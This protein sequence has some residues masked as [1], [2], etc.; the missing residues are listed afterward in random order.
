[1]RHCLLA[2]IALSAGL[3]SPPA[4]AAQER[5]G[6]IDV[7][8][9]EDLRGAPLRGVTVTAAGTQ[10]VST[11][12]DAGGEAHFV[13]LPTGSYTVIATQRGYNDYH[14][15]NI[16]VATGMTVP[17]RIWMSVAAP[18]RQVDTRID[19]PLVETRAHTASTAVSFDELQRVPWTRDPW[20]VL[21]TV[22]AVIV[23]R[24]NVGSL[25]SGQQ[26]TFEAKGAPP[27]DNTWA[28]EGVPVTSM[29]APG[30]SMTYFDFGMLDELRVT[31]GGA[32]PHLASPGVQVNVLL[33]SGGNEWRGAG[34]AYFGDHRMQSKNVADSMRPQLSSF[35][36]AGDY[37]D[38]GAE[39]GGPIVEGRIFGWAGAG[40][41]EPE[42]RI[43]ASGLSDTGDVET[44]RDSTTLQSYAG[45]VTAG[46][47]RDTRALFTYF[48]NRKQ[49]QGYGATATRPQDA[50]FDEDASATLY[51]IAIDRQAGHDVFLSARYA[52]TGSGLSLTPRGG[53]AFFS[54]DRPQEHAAADA[55]VFRRSHQLAFGIGWRS[56]SDRP[57]FPVRSDGQYWTAYA[58]DTI[59][60][61]RLTVAA[62]AR[63]DR[64]RSAAG[65]RRIV[66]NSV[67]PRIGLTYVVDNDQ[68]TLLRGSYSM[69]PS[70]LAATAVE[71]LQATVGEYTTPRTHEVVVG[72]DRYLSS[73]ITMTA[74]FTW[75]RMTGMNWVHHR[76]ITGSDYAQI[77]SIG[78]D[79]PPVGAFDVPLYRLKPGTVPGGL[80]RVFETRDGYHQRYWGAEVAASKRFSNNWALRVGFSTNDHR[81]YFDGLDAIADPTRTLESP[82]VN[83]GP[84]VR[85]V[86]APGAT[87]IFM[88][89]PK[90]Q[91][92][93]TIS[94]QMFLGLDAA[95]EYALRQG[96]PTPYYASDMPASLDPLTGARRN[97]LLVQ[98]PGRA[99]LSMAHTLDG[100]LSKAFT[101]SGVHVYAL[102]LDLDVFNVLNRAIVTARGYD[103]AR[104]DFNRIL[105]MTSPRT[106]RLGVR[107]NF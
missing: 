35:S 2:S 96:Y 54:T 10:D 83:G 40:R 73:G 87:G 90:Y 13:D 23:D 55:Y 60:M 86:D 16:R 85:R 51:K 6:R 28:L 97:V 38:V 68:T 94:Y 24:V 17:L 47:D 79:L 78:G 19:A 43:F 101:T 39:G 74:L 37:K 102:H 63:W 30:S 27:G 20:T 1:M 95:L 72:G 42:R 46:I 100:R 84:V 48:H 66:W 15:I 98:D 44:A 70:Q 64:A 65:S 53:G 58:G 32:S 31:T 75:R 18:T 5:P 91:F 41:T 67:T 25:D 93:G 57:T 50:V 56:T 33:R 3:V 8:V 45:K 9:R 59:V 12:T 11:V 7:V 69:L 34:R 80:E 82:N 29:A 14:S 99:R 107:V 52:H 89:A 62:A 81:E 92:A 76:G 26:L 77:G 106:V 103:L 105:G 104:A 88:V 49:E 4:A 22:P 71:A 21:Q 36:R 61:R